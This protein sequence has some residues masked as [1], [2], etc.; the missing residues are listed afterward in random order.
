MKNQ[1]N[2]SLF[3]NHEINYPTKV[4]KVITVQANRSRLAEVITGHH[5]HTPT[6]FV[7]NPEL[8]KM[9]IV[10]HKIDIVF[11]IVKSTSVETLIQ[12]PTLKE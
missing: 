6:T 1:I 9:Q 12:K 8:D 2:L 10:F 4:F 3:T 7:D 11:Q 5:Y